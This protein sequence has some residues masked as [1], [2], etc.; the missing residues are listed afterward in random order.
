VARVGCIARVGLDHDDVWGV[1]RDRRARL[2]DGA[3]DDHSH[4]ARPL[5]T[6]EVHGALLAAGM[7]PNGRV[8]NLLVVTAPVIRLVYLPAFVLRASAKL[9]CRTRKTIVPKMAS[10]ITS[11]TV[12]VST[13]STANASRPRPLAPTNRQ[14]FNL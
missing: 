2:R 7:D 5:N 10:V 11:A 3:R 4:V 8:E 9:Q 14:S 13:M 6:A 1:T 12:S